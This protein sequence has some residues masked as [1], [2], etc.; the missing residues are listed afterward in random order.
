MIPIQFKIFYS[1]NIF[2]AVNCFS[3]LQ[4]IDSTDVEN[5]FIVQ[6]LIYWLQ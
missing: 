3:L 5:I 2:K 4:V 1:F 6:K